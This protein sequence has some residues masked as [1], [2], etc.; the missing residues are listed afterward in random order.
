MVRRAGG[1]GQVTGG[2]D[3]GPD[4]RRFAACPEATAD[5]SVPEGKLVLAMGSLDGGPAPPEAEGRFTG[6]IKPLE[7]R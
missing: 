4:T 1:S 7:C 5:L 2:A 6:P 3:P